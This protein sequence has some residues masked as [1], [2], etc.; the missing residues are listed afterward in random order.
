MV[1][2]EELGD[3]ESE[4]NAESLLSTIDPEQLKKVVRETAEKKLQQVKVELQ[5]KI[6]EKEAVMLKNIEKLKV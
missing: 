1:S 5:S 4:K 3:N 2:E 6:M